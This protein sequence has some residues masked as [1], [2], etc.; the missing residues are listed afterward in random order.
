MSTAVAPESATAST[1][2]VQP[3]G[4]DLVTVERYR[5]HG[6]PHDQ[7]KRLRA[8]QP[9]C[10]HEAPPHAG[11]WAVTKYK[12][13]QHISRTPQDFSSWRG[14]TNLEDYGEEDIGPI[15]MLLVNMDPPQHVKYRK[16]ISRGFT[17]RMVKVMKPQIED[18][19]DRLL[20]KAAGLGGEFDFVREVAAEFPLEVLCDFMGVP[21]E[22]TDK[23]FDWSNRLIGFDDPEF[24]TSMDDAR[25]ASMELWMYTQELVESRLGQEDDG[26]DLIRVLLNAELDGERLT[27]ADL[28]GFFL[29]PLGRRQR[30]DAKRNHRWASRPPR[31]PGPAAAPARESRRA[32]GFGDRGDSALGLP[33]ELL[34]AHGDSRPD[35]QRRAHEGETTRCASSTRP[36]TGTRTFSRTPTSSTSPARRT[37]TSRSVSASTSASAPAWLGSSSSRCSAS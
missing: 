26:K 15:R 1:P 33:A 24:Q 34:P 36:R 37:R 31:A 6:P 28:N 5:D 32:H 35:A 17:P 14:G 9:I 30:D 10:W 13:I 11:F 27:E 19:V 29:A 16:L 8:E 3:D 21:Q 23:I 18:S 2:K 25:M 20:T 22:D 7:Y 12:D 4:I